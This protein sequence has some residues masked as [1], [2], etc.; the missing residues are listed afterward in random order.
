M[1]QEMGRKGP[2]LLRLYDRLCYGCAYISVWMMLGIILSINYEVF[3]RYFFSSPTKWVND[4]TD[5][6]L[7]YTTFLA[8]A[9]LLKNDEHIRLTFML[10]RLSPRSRRVMGVINSFI[11]MIVCGYLIWY[12][13]A[14]TWD[15]IKNSIML[16]RPIPVPKYYII[17]VI[18]F[19]CLILLAQF[20]LDAFK[21]L[22]ILNGRNQ[23]E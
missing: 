12:A 23:S 1:N 16:P 11:G 21:L 17:V 20:I 10:D 13:T 22:G 14:D 7:L 19:A 15:A 9:W 2:I 6:T 4:F 3:A 8:S 18:P 5:Y